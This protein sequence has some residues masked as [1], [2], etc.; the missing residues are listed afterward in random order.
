[1]CKLIRLEWKKNRIGKYVF[2]AVMI[3][4]I[5]CLFTF[6]MAFLGIAT[7]P[8]GTLDAAPSGAEYIS[9]TI[10]LLTSMAFLLLTSVMLSNF[11]ISAYKNKIMDLMFSY[12]IS[13]RKILTSQMLA[14]WI[15]C[16]VFLFLS[17]CAIYL[18]ILVSSQFLESPFVIDIYMAS[19]MFY[20][21]L[22]VHSFVLVS[23]G[24]ISLFVGLAM[25]SS[26]AAMAAA[27]LLFFVTQANI[28]D[29][30]LAHNVAAPLILT[31]ISFGFALL[32]LSQ[33]ESRD[34]I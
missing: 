28:G 13:R 8:D 27:I 33:A 11:I 20:L 24:F 9:A 34:L 30:T 18:C 15:F 23:M 25:K 19:P 17:R 1:M 4:L 29:L 14:V 6:A 32:I 7:D 10:D 16:F 21:Q 5:I 3:T 26:K 12:P 2:K 22:A 31:V